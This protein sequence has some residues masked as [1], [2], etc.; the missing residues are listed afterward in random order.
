MYGSN[1]RS[2]VSHER[3]VWMDF[4][5]YQDIGYSFLWSHTILFAI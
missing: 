3:A 4:G 5:F 2:F 1:Q